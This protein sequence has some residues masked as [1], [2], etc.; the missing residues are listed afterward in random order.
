MFHISQVTICYVYPAKIHLWRPVQRTSRR[1]A[2][3]A[4]PGGRRR[5][6]HRRGPAAERGR[7]RPD[8]HVRAL[9]PF[10]DSLI[11]HIFSQKCLIYHEFSPY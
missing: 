9:H 4:V 3:Q 5:R 11:V 1:G 6:H 7:L 10:D 2:G 8:E